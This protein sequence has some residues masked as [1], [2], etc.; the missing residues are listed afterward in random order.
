MSSAADPGS[1]FIHPPRK[2]LLAALRAGALALIFSVA[3]FGTGLFLANIRPFAAVGTVREKFAYFAAHKDDYSALFLGSSRVYRGIL[4][5]LFDELTASQGAPTRSFNFGID[6][7]FPPEDAAVFEQIV[8]LR[9]KNLRWVF[10]ESSMFLLDFEGRDPESIRA[11]YWHDWPRTR[12]VCAELFRGKKGTL[13]WRKLFFGNERERERGS[14]VLAHARAFVMRA[15]NLGRATTLFASWT[16]GRTQPLEKV[17]GQNLDG[18]YPMAAG[19][20]LIHI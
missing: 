11:V 8:A 13:S 6:G 9:P 16:K 2:P 19:L 7:M 4:P 10:I 14:L 5:S 1:A 17:L 15:L 18:F 20:S 3:L 12:L